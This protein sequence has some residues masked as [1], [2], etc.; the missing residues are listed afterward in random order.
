MNIVNIKKLISYFKIFDFDYF[1]G[2][3]FFFYSSGRVSLLEIKLEKSLVIQM[4]SFF[5]GIGGFILG[6]KLLYDQSFRYVRFF[7]VF[8][9]IQLEKVSVKGCYKYNKLVEINI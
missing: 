9:F 3:L 7:D 5:G 4:I 6:V 8:V 2:Y 1:N